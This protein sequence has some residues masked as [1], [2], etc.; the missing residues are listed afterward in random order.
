M[1]E[2]FWNSG[3]REKIKGL[4]IL[5]VRQ[6]DQNLEQRWVA[7]I[8]TIS[9]RARYLSLLPW[10]MAEYYER[11][12]AGGARVRYDPEAVTALLSRLEFVVLACTRAGAENG[13]EGPT[14]YLLG[15]DKFRN[16]LSQ[17]V[18]SGKVKAPSK[19]GGAT[20][21]T[22]I[23]PCRSF[24]LLDTVAAMDEEP[25]RI[26]P[27]GRKLYEARRETL[28]DSTLARV[29]LKGGTVSS[30]AVNT[31]YAL[32]SANGLDMCPKE[33]DVLD[34]AFSEPF[35]D[36]RGVADTYNRFNKTVAWV[37]SAAAEGSA[38]ADELIR[39]NLQSV[40]TS[41]PGG[42]TDVGLAWTECDLHRRV[43]FALELLLSCYA[44]V[45][46]DLTAGNT[47]D[48]LRAV[49][50]ELDLVELVQNHVSKKNVSPA[51]RMG[52]F[53][54]S[55]HDRAFLGHTIDARSARS[56]PPWSRAVYGLAL[57][58][59]CERTSRSIREKG[60]LAGIGDVLS[61]AFS[62]VTEGQ[63]STVGDVLGDLMDDVV[64][65]P[66]LRTSLRKL[67]N[68][69]KCSLRF[70]PD[71]DTLR[72]TG[73]DV[74]PGYSGSRLGNVLGMLADIGRCRRGPSGYEITDRGRRWL[75]KRAA[76]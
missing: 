47:A 76:K 57:I 13:E 69:Q 31:E 58:I 34:G 17:L 4:D 51:T 30:A 60:L 22:Y 29:V 37:L 41:P 46:R 18:E 27:R 73:T 49:A 65:Q 1:A 2:T 35:L 54:K 38:I 55:V 15:A 67:G 59:S 25:I 12:L 52:A 33:R 70:Y 21:G 16:E 26:T 8:T 10:A 63:D 3:E 32:F 61:R 6:H 72:P 64:V 36:T 68:G 5:G 44:E 23:M 48:V 53:S 7:G 20:Y 71:G 40:L 75:E 43:H 28:G 56:V 24:G 39:D 9:Y 42:A 14:T 74:R 19:G 45:L 11:S 66:H 62:I 50:R